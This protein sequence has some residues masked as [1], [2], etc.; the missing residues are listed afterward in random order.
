MTRKRANDPNKPEWLLIETFDEDA[1]PSVVSVGSVPNRFRPL[2][3]LFSR[4]EARAKAV[5]E[6]VKRVRDT[7]RGINEEGHGRRIIVDPLFLENRLHG[8]WVWMNSAEIPV[9]T[10]AAAGAWIIDLTTHKALGSTEWAEMADIPSEHRGQERHMGAMFGQV[11]IKDGGENRALSL[12]ETKPIGTDLQGDWNVRRRDGSKWRA[13]FSLRIL[14]VERSGEI[15]RCSVGLSQNLGEI[16]QGSPEPLE[17]IEGH[18]LRL[19]RPDN[20]HAAIVSP[21]NLNFIRWVTE[22]SEFVAWRG[23]AGEPTPGI[24]PEDLKDA[25][26]LMRRAENIGRAEGQIRLMGSD[27]EY[28][29]ANLV[30]SPV[31]LQEDVH[32]AFVL[33]RL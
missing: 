14:E 29:Q 12:I 22:A 19:T 8:A 7:G 28:L 6:L 16:G 1:L 27:G 10:H 32:A 26:D 3:S 2:S 4:N 23:V 24:H 9:P 25:V 20:E 31:A 30:I 13:H 18:Y 17:S 5:I 15:H 21:R 33:I 11:D